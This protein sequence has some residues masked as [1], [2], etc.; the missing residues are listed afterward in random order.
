VAMLHGAS[1]R[2]VQLL[3]GHST[4]RMTKRYTATITSENVVVRHSQFSPVDKMYLK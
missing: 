3:L 2:E 4:D 1:E